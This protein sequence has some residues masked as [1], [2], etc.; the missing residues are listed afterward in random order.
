MKFRPH[1]IGASQGIRHDAIPRLQGN[2]EGFAL[3]RWKARDKGSI[4]NG[5]QAHIKAVHYGIG[6]D[7]NCPACVE[8]QAK[9]AEVS[10]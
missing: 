3:M 9:L 4:A 5:L 1:M 10:K 8:L 6:A 2:D 7:A